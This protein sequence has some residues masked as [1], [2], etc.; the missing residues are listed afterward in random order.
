VKDWHLFQ[1]KQ[2]SDA[3]QTPAGASLATGKG[4]QQQLLVNKADLECL[5]TEAMMLKEFLPKVLTPEY[6]TSFSKLTQIDQELQMV[7]QE[8]EGLSCEHEHLKRRTEAIMADYEQE[9]QEK[10]TAKVSSIE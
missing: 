8:K 6:L 10:F 4:D 5:V 9:K 3:L 2:Q 1:H 7:A